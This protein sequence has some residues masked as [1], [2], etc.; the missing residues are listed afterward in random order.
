MTL[1]HLD[2]VAVR[3][4]DEE[5]AREQRAVAVELDDPARGEAGG[6]EAGV[7]GVEIVDD[8]GDVAV[9][10]A[11]VVGLGAALVDGELDLEIGLGLRR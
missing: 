1:E 9:A 6:L 5:E 7:L 3:V 2:L 10:V 4:G 8:E 11:E